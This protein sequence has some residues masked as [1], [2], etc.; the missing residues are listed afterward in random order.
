MS[1]TP[2]IGVRNVLRATCKICTFVSLVH[3]LE[4]LVNDG[5]QELPVC[6]E[7]SRVLADNVHDIRR[8]HGLIVLS[9][10]DFAQPKQILDDRDQESL[11][12][13]LVCN[14][15]L[16]SQTRYFLTNTHS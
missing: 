15:W 2:V 13:L 11:L 6:L 4:Q 14:M 7:E 9:T 5:L 16:A 3:E 8:D 1:C 10:L 12:G